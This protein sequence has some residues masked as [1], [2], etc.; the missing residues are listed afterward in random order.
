[1]VWV[2]QE[3][4]NVEVAS[5]DNDTREFSGVYNYRAIIGCGLPPGTCFDT[6][7]S[8]VGF[9]AV[10][11]VDNDSWFHV[12]NH[13]GDVVYSTTTGVSITIKDLGAYPLDTTCI[14]PSTQYDRWD[15]VRWVTDRAAQ[16]AEIIAE[17]VSQKVQLTASA[18]QSISPLTRAK[19]LGIATDEELAALT[20]WEHYSVFLMRVD[21]SKA[22]DITWPTP[23]TV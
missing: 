20:E 4:C 7:E 10:R 19:Q 5:Y 23:P 17:A 8:R 2:A 12:E 1:M 11:D 15:G 3:T 14:P 16:I 21:T 6:P 22:P 13:R 9:A 18:E